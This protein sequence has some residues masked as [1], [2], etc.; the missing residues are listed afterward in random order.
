MIS[1]SG[2]LA[3][4]ELPPQPE[5]RDN[6]A[7]RGRRGTVL[8]GAAVLLVAL[9]VRLPTLFAGLPYLNYV[10]EGHILHR[11][12]NLLRN[13]GWDP[14]WY[15][16]PAL[17][18]YAIAGAA[19]LYSPVYR[20]LHGQPLAADLS[21][22]PAT[23][24]D[25]I[26]PPELLV[27]GRALTLALALGSVAAT[28]RLAH[29]LAGP[30]S[31]LLAAWLAALVP[32][33]VI[34]GA[35]LNVDA[36]AVF[37]TLAALCFAER[38]RSSAHPAR[39][40]AAAGAMTGLAL[41]SKYPAVL[42]CLPVTL[43][44]LLASRGWRQRA[45][46][47]ALAGAMAAAAAALGMPALVLRT[48]AVIQAL[49]YESSL[50]ATGAIGSYWQQAV[51]QAEWDQ[52]YRG[53]ELGLPFLALAAAGLW[54]ALADRRWAPA[55]WGWLLLAGGL[56]ALFAPFPFRAFRNLLALVPLAAILISLLY[57]RLRQ[58]ARRAW[59]ADAAAVA[60]PLLLFGAPVG[61]YALERLAL[62]DSRTQAARWLAAH[63]GP[64]D[65]TMFA[66]E[67][68]F[69]PTQLDALP[70]ECDVFSWPR[71]RR[72]LGDERYRYLVLGRLVLPGAREIPRQVWDGEVLTR[73]D[74]RADFGAD[75]AP[76]APWIFP[77]NRLKVYILESR[78]AR[79]TRSASRA[80]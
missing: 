74:L 62:A 16:Y 40:A 46:R 32:A 2:D 43:A 12:V 5:P 58:A 34:R 20:R 31:G 47:L 59:V 29:R 44:V 6:R 55:A 71:F 57:A 17:P 77:G 35:A 76:E 22:E 4:L 64:Q 7:K 65:A 19:W 3:T 60:L 10:D 61:R 73:Y 63:S 50:Y 48:G 49:T 23:Y 37:F 53:P 26:D 38:L 56:G 28:G 24:Y 79:G 1:R 67:L 69:L 18:N 39:E 80:P 45:G 78:A 70:G 66:R 15:I 25:I 11:V 9:A 21:E 36:W 13:G 52:P 51:A 33:L 30:A 42:V 8:L 41:V 75:P 14:G 68:A 72:G 27:F 54:V